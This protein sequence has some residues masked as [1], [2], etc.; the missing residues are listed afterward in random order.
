MCCTGFIAVTGA[1]ITGYKLAGVL[2]APLLQQRGVGAAFPGQ[3]GKIN[4]YLS[5]RAFAELRGAG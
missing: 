1:H 2:L 5:S 3:L 4:S